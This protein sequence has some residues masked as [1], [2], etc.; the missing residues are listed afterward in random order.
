MKYLD[1]RK[2]LIAL[3][4]AALST[5]TSTTEITKIN[6]TPTLNLIAS[7][8]AI[9][10]TMRDIVNVAN[11]PAVSLNLFFKFIVSFL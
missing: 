3:A 4:Q 9:K 2:S 1:T 8:K 6:A 7:S 11:P 5:P 10:S